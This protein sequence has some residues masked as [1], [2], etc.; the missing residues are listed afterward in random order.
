MVI[1]ITKTTTEESLKNSIEH[2]RNNRI[3]KNKS[4]FSEFFGIL[5]NIED[6]LTFQKRARNEWD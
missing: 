3:Q 2:F 6:G 1:E 5:P 4:N